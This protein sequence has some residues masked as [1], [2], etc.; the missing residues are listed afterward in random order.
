MPLLGMGLKP[1]C[2]E[3]TG[4][5]DGMGRVSIHKACGLVFGTFFLAE[6]VIFAMLIMK[7]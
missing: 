4:W 7:T 5:M 3:K 2:A 6:K 1:V